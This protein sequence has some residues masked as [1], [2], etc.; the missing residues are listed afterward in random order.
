MAEATRDPWQVDRQRVVVEQVRDDQIAPR[1]LHDQCRIEQTHPFKGDMPAEKG[2]ERGELRRIET[3]LHKQPNVK[4]TGRQQ[5]FGGLH[6][7][8]MVGV[9]S[10]SQQQP[11]SLPREVGASQTQQRLASPFS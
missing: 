4:L 2:I 11:A 3:G 1:G 10:R 9:P 6:V 5:R 8:R 7:A